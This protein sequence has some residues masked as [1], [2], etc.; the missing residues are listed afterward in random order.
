MK[1]FALFLVLAVSVAHAQTP[2]PVV[3]GAATAPPIDD[4]S[5]KPTRAD[6]ATCLLLDTTPGTLLEAIDTSQLATP[7]PWNDFTVNGKFIDGD[8]KETLHAIFD[9]TFTDHHTNFTAAT[10]REIAALAAKFG[11]QLVGHLVQDTP[12]GN[13]LVVHVEPLPLVRHIK[14]VVNSDSPAFGLFD[15]LLDDEVGRRLRVRAGSYLPWEPIRRQCAIADERERVGAYLHDEGYADATVDIVQS[16]SNDSSVELR[17]KVELGTK[18]VVGRVR[19]VSPANAALPWSKGFTAELER[20]FHHSQL[21]LDARFTR[22][23]H[24]EDLIAV[25][26]KVHKLGYPEARVTSSFDPQ[27]SFDRRTHTVNLTITIDPRREVDVRFDPS[28]IGGVSQDDLRKQL[29]FDA[30]GS[31]DDVEA[32]SSAR[33]LVGFLQARGYF[34]ARV[35][36]ER[37]RLPEFD[38]ITFYLTAGPSREVSS[39]TFSGEHVMPL[40]TLQSTVATKAASF[41]V[42]F[43]SG[44]NTSATSAQLEE[45]T[46][47]ITELYRKAGYRETRVTATASTTPA[48]LD[49]AALTAA[50]V[51][52]DHGS[53][54]YVHFAIDEGQATLLTRIVVDVQADQAKQLA[55]C[56]SVLKEL[57]D[58]LGEPQF[59]VRDT[60]T[61]E[62]C[63]ATAANFAFS[64]DKVTATRDGLRDFLYRT[65]RPRAIVDYDA[66]PLGPH[67][68]TARYVVRSTD[69]LR[70]GKVV[71]RGNFKTKLSVILDELRLPEGALLTNDALADGARRLR[72]TG[73]FDA[74]NIELPDLCGALSTSSANCAASSSVV[75]AVVRVEERYDQTATVDL[76]TGYSSYQGLFGGF[77]FAMRNLGG[78]G[79]VWTVN[80]TE[81]TKITDLEST[82][83]IPR[84]LDPDWIPDSLRFRTE[85]TG[86]YKQQDTPR[87]GQLTTEGASVSLT[88][89][90][91]RQ[92]TATTAARVLTWNMLRYDFRLRTREVDALRPIGTNQDEPQVAISTRTSSVG[93]AFE[94]EAR[95]DRNGVLAPLAPEAGY[96]FEASAAYAESHFLGQD[97]FLKL[98]ATGSK[99]YSP[100]DNLV[101]RGDLRVDWG[102]P[103]GGA[104]LL[105]EVERFFAGGDSTVRGY[106]DDRM[107]TELI[108][109]GLPPFGANLSQIRIIPAGGNIRVLA[110]I[111]A[112]LQIWKIIAGALFSDAGMITNQWNSASPGD[113]RPS[114]GMGIR[115]ITPFGIGALE[116]AIPLRPQ[117]GDD[118]RGRIHFYF[119]ARAQF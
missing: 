27:L 97:T 93:M 16:I 53:D 43:I 95:T 80:A 15:K 72:N 52:A 91:I 18:Y 13:R 84:W 75:N 82:L 32:A 67:R 47:R 4:G 23:Q 102:I 44:D 1:L 96:R 14:T 3:D 7:I 57:A 24:Q 11:Y 48:G 73:L 109:V 104:V 8:S 108:Q 36:F 20:M 69:Q 49:N 78:Y 54:L 12:N 101:I 103:L 119:A 2:A 87:F 5:L 65:G 117:L 115:F 92:H 100:I 88:R 81:G 116:Y 25:R 60:S 22:T 98:S 106:S 85:L 29:T 105:P 90:S 77:G 33:A 31:A 79:L 112:Q 111:D 62:P 58:E 40:A 56:T 61:G 9:P 46:Q 38:R 30:A 42:S 118:P 89:Q 45:D 55:L 76:V 21:W 19:I 83:Q 114:V 110:S 50:L 74:V 63:V 28:D 26:D 86:L 113:I 66:K 51:L 35:T 39:V 70:I 107:A 37:N 59:A 99:Y 41:R 34:D 10:W 6:R 94:W 71:V 17:V 68:V 64:E